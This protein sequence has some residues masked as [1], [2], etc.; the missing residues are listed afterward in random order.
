MVGVPDL[1]I[2]R[3]TYAGLVCEAGKYSCKP[4]L[5]LIIL[6]AIALDTL[7]CAGAKTKL[8]MTY[9]PPWLECTSTTRD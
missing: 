1:C 5:S 8:V 9:A 6:V 2:G 7:S 4:G 3:V